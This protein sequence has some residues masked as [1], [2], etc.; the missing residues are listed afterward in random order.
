MQHLPFPI[1]HRNFVLVQPDYDRTAVDRRTDRQICC[2][3]WGLF[4]AK[5]VK[6]CHEENKAVRLWLRNP[7]ERRKSDQRHPALDADDGAS[8]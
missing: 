4:E 3:T 5:V 1:S 7:G 8:V 2:K 6:L